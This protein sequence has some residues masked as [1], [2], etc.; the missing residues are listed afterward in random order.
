MAPILDWVNAHDVLLG[1]LSAISALMFFGSL[2]AVPW[3]VL[4]IPTDYFIHRRHV[5]DR[6][7]SRHP[8]VRIGLLTAKNLCG[9]VLV[10][11]GIAMLVFPGQGIL[12]IFVG[13]MCLDFPGKYAMEQRLVRQRPVLGAINW[14]RAKGKRPPLELPEQERGSTGR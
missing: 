4:R 14:M 8:L 1:W 2:I 3:L 10:L 12:T 7:R 6:W 5:V 9:I 13:L 11:A